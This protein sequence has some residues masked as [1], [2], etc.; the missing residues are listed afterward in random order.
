MIKIV[1]PSCGNTEFFKESYYPKTLCEVSGEPMLQLVVDNYKSLEEK[2]FVFLFLQEECNRF[3]T[4]NIARLLTDEN[5]DIVRLKSI[6]GG[7]LCTCLMAVEY[8]NTEDAIIITNND[9]IINTDLDK[10]IA[11]FEKKKSD[12]GVICFKSVHPRWTYIRA[13]EKRV[14]E[15][16]EKRPISKNAIAGFYY[17]RHGRDFIKAACRA[18]EKGADYEGR[19]YLSA[20]INE[21][22]L[23]NK[24]VDIYPIEAVN[25]K[26]FYS[27]EKISIYEKEMRTHEKS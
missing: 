5:C 17:F 10:V 9:Q 14:L 18:I 25:Y 4:D 7:A 22:I 21:M 3:H 20:S 27:P 13:E 24:N 1:V 26:S 23:M 15:A 6:T 11:F 16:A 12:C 19:Y 2:R 8:I